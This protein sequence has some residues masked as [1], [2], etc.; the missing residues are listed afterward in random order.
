MKILITKNQLNLLKESLVNDEELRNTIKSFESTVVDKNGNHYVFDDKDPKSPKTFV[1]SPKDK[2]GGTLTIGWGHTGDLAKIGKKI[3]NS[4]AERLL[5]QDIKKEEEKTKKLF[6][7]YNT[8]PDYVQRALVNA[9]Y[10]GEAKSSYEW[11]KEINNDNWE[12]AS[13]KYLQGWN[14]D[15]SKADD[16]RYQGG[17]ADR[18]KTNQRAF[19]KYA[20]ERKNKTIQKPKTTQSV[21]KETGGK[22]ERKINLS[23]PNWLKKYIYGR[24][25]YATKTRDTD[26]VNIRYTPEVNN[27]LIDNKIGMVKYPNPVGIVKDVKTVGL[28]TW[29]YMKLDPSVD[30]EDDYGWV[31]YKYV[32]K[33]QQ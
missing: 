23:D 4:D 6:P 29:L 14:V 33:V 16:P 24:K 8:Y 20:K 25:Y 11:V 26:F 17:V 1:K 31:N 18:M 21:E 15:F 3:S 2:K 10:R 7:K 5:S 22:D 12:T 32:S 19:L 28:D 9:V 30:A 27:G 13:K